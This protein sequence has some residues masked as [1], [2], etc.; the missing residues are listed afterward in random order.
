MAT[1]GLIC[2]AVGFALLSA[3][4]LIQAF[5][6]DGN[7]PGMA[8]FVFPALLA[9]F[10]GLIL[11]E[12]AVLRSNVLPRWLAVFF[13]LST[14]SLVMFNEQAV[15]VLLAIPFGLAMVAA[16]YL[17]WTGATGYAAAPAKGRKG[18]GGLA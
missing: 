11:I 5:A 8:F 2:T 6:F 14:V 4:G 9:I 17:M 10:V 3:G 18:V 16:G 1:A 12:I 13:I 15:T 7:F